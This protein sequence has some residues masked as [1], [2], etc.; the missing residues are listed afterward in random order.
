[1]DSS[2]SRY[3]SVGKIIARDLS[4]VASDYIEWLFLGPGSHVAVTPGSEQFAAIGPS[5]II[6]VLPLCL[7]EPVAVIQ[8]SPAD[9]LLPRLPLLPTGRPFSIDRGSSYLIFLGDA[10]RH[11]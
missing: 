7:G 11:C 5:P 8:G 9:P 1:V 4:L 2:D 10:L 3:I 6:Q